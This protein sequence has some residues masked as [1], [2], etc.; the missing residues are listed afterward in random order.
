MILGKN[1]DDW[2][3][4]KY[5]KP[6]R[7]SWN[8]STFTQARPNSPKPDVLEDL[9]QANSISPRRDRSNDVGYFF[10]QLAHVSPITPRREVT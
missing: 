6:T 3:E 8:A 7:E 10:V 2:A 5:I 1:G 9:A 4:G